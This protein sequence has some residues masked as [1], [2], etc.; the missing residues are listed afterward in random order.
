MDEHVI[1]M[2]A[3]DLRAVGVGSAAIQTIWDQFYA[4]NW[5]DVA[6]AISWA[7]KNSPA[8]K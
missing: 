4:S 3:N 5:N 2:I 7:W 1:Q 8:P 6:L